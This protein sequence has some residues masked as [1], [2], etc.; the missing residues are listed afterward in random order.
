MDQREVLRLQ[1]FADDAGKACPEFGGQL[2]RGCGQLFRTHVVRRRVDEVACEHRGIRHAADLG[3]VDA[4]RRHQPDLGAVRLAIAGEAVAAEREGERRQSRIVRCIGKAIGAR[5]QQAR[6]G[7]RPEQ[8]ARSGALVLDPEQHLRDR[9]VR[10]RAAP[11]SR[12]AWRQRR[13]RWRTGAAPAAAFRATAIPARFGDEGDRDGGGGRLEDGR[14]WRVRIVRS[15]RSCERTR[16]RRV[17]PRLQSALLS[18]FSDPL[19]AARGHAG[20]RQR[21]P[22]RLGKLCRR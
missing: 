5:R 1:V 12:P 19:L 2:L 14:H 8:V 10:A 16:L 15:S 11:D 20:F 6:Q 9:A 17:S 21:P 18:P 13:W 3:C 7:A 4:V 22:D